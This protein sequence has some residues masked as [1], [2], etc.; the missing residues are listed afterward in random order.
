MDILITITQFLLALSL[1]I[2][3]HEGGHFFFA[4]LFKTRVEKFYLFFD[5]LFPFS[6]ILPFSLWKKKKGD[7]EYGIGWFPLG[8]YVKIAGMVDESMDK[9][10]MAKPPQPWEFRS[11]KPWQ[12]LLIMLGGIIVNV[13]L[14][15][16]IFAG[17][18]YHWGTERLPMAEVNRNG[19]IVIMD[20]I[21]HKAGMMDGD[22]VI[23]IDKVP[24]K[25]FEDLNI[26]F[27]TGRTVSILREGK[28]QTITLPVDLIGQ[29]VDAKRQAPIFTMNIPVIVASTVEG[30]NAEKAG[31]APRD[32]IIKAAGSNVPNLKVLQNILKG[33]VDRTVTLSVLRGRQEIEVP[34][35]VG[36][37]GLLGFKPGGPTKTEEFAHFGYHLEVQK[38]GFWESFPAGI[39]M[40]GDKLGSYMKQMKTVLNPSTG[41]Y[42][43]VGGFV[44]MAKVFG[45]E[46][47]WYRFWN[48]TATLSLILAFMNFL[49]IPGLDGGYVVFT[50]W[51]MITGRKPNEKFLEVATTIGLV[52]LLFLMLYANLNDVFRNF[53]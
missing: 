13:L 53:F 23:A 26:E 17:I 28:E 43:G 2:V 21:G 11:K 15:F 3:L 48:I 1:L 20:S 51:E 4:R 41:G 12:R 5:F 31:L 40:A 50:L 49:P 42:K 34:V 35:L 37:D 39:A 16:V 44:S 22:E 30:S 18:V 38:Y 45:P 6:N 9:E 10:Q 33:Y 46:W 25:Y 7:T 24:I 27:I 47:D 8:G 19:G 36:Q 52:F 32:Q 29:L 14:A